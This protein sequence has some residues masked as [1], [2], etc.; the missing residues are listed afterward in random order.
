ML[1][2][3][4]KPMTI[5]PAYQ[6][7]GTGRGIRLGASVSYY[8]SFQHLPAHPERAKPIDM[9]TYPIALTRVAEGTQLEI[10][11]SDGHTQLVK[12]RA[13]RDACPC[14]TCRERAEA[15]EEQPQRQQLRILSDAELQPVAVSRMS[16][17]GSYAYLIEFSDGH[18]SGIFTFD[19]LRKI[20]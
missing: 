15:V 14:A 12:S 16:P 18:R 8:P 4:S 11:W 20:S 1:G 5:D 13:L 7:R 2:P 17:T 19:Y 3:A 10:Q 6:S 9:D